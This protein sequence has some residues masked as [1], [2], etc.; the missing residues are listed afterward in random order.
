M[1]IKEKINNFIKRTFHDEIIAVEPPREFWMEYKDIGP[2]LEGYITTVTYKY[3]GKQNLV[4]T[5]DNDHFQL[6]SPEKALKNA[7]NFYEKV[8]KKIKNSNE[9]TK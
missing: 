4:S 6:I 9:N 1:T 5:I 7:M 3:R 2:R 8:T